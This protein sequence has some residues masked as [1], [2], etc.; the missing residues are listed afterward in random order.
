MNV[1]V[2]FDYNKVLNNQINDVLIFIRIGSYI[3]EMQIVVIS[4]EYDLFNVFFF[5]LENLVFVINNF[6]IFNFVV[7]GDL[8]YYSGILVLYNFF[9]FLIKEYGIYMF[10]K[11]IVFYWLKRCFIKKWI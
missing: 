7:F 2:V 4:I 8:Y 10:I 11:Q 1:R 6:F 9:D 3:M 5:K